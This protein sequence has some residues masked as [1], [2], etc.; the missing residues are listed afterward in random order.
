LSDECREE[1]AERGRVLALDGRKQAVMRCPEKGT[2]GTSHSRSIVGR[3]NKIGID[4]DDDQG[5]II[6]RQH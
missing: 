6:Y 4:S 2:C 1:L 3:K 5:Y